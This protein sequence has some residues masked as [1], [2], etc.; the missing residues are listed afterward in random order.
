MFDLVKLLNEFKNG[1]LSMCIR[2]LNLFEVEKVG[3]VI[4]WFFLGYFVGF[5]F[6]FRMW[7]FI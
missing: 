3:G 6:Y 1:Y 4:V 2:L 5:F 7:Y